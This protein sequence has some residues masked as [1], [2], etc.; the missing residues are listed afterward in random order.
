ME[1]TVIITSDT[2]ISGAH[3][4]AG[5]EKTYTVEE[6]PN[7]HLLVGPVELEH[8]KAAQRIVE[9]DSIGHKQFIKAQEALKRKEAPLPATKK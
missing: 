7:S 6:D 8:L 5:T 9:K 1:L 2:Y 4:P 3:V